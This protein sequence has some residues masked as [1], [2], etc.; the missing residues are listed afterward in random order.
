MR[1]ESFGKLI[2]DGVAEV[3]AEIE[4]GMRAAA[5]FDSARRGPGRGN[6]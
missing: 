3:G 4:G 1:I 5:L 6:T 2:V